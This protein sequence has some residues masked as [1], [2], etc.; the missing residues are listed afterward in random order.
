VKAGH[1][2]CVSIVVLQ[3]LDSTLIQDS[4]LALLFKALPILR[5]R[6]EKRL[7]NIAQPAWP[8][9]KILKSRF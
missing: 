8:E 9:A 7:D 6:L 2:S 5:T 4:R 1:G 3:K